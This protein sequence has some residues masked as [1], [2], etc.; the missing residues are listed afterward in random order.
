M[1]ELTSLRDLGEAL[2]R[3]LRGPSPQLRHKV[4]TDICG[5][6]GRARQ[7]LPR[8]GA[9]RRLVVTA[10]LAVVLAGALLVASTLRLWGGSPAASAQAAEI[11]R[12]AAV[13]AKHQPALTAGPSQFIYVNSVESGAQITVS[14]RI[15]HLQIITDLRD[16]WLSA[17]GTRNGLLREQRRSPASLGRP[18]GPWQT[19]PLPGCRD[20]RLNPVA[21]GG[22]SNGH[23]TPTP[24]YLAGLPT[25][26][27]AMLAYL[28]QH[29][30]GQNPPD[31]QAF[32][33]AGDLIRESYARPAALAALFAA[34]AQIPGVSLAGHAVNAAG[35]QGVAVQ[36]AFHGTSHQL[37]FN[38]RTHA[39]I[40]EREV[41]VSASSGL[42]VG[43]VLDSTAVLRLAVVDHVGQLP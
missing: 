34:A 12:L 40:G 25:S 22:S 13:T 26:T 17:A 29:S 9:G 11:L 19:I 41:V 20:G 35:Q 23:C 18:A 16:I 1:N 39:F 2:D 27:Q 3:E 38:P 7:R 36:Q 43:T 5:R 24:A 42:P 30:Q 10:A 28:Y 32:I 31:V 14:G 33:T 6:P 37:I 15:T 8:L 4:I 21:G